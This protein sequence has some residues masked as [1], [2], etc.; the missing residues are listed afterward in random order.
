MRR[1]ASTPAWDAQ[2]RSQSQKAICVPR[3]PVA[4]Q[5]DV[6][7]RRRNRE[8]AGPRRFQVVETGSRPTSDGPHERQGLPA[9]PR[10]DHESGG[11]PAAPLGRH[12]PTKETD[13]CRIGRST[14]RGLA[15]F[16]E[17]PPTLVLGGC[18]RPACTPS[19]GPPRPHRRPRRRLS[20][21]QLRLAASRSMTQ[22]SPTVLQNSPE[23]I[24]PFHRSKS[25]CSLSRAAPTEPSS[26]NAVRITSFAS[27]WS[28]R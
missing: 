2:R 11:E 24:S 21:R 5:R 14:G 3:G 20:V 9:N 7:R 15:R 16:A 27:N 4:N 19:A 26:R 1:E 23:A 22:D 6:L 17:S 13:Y 18:A 10:S 8:S 28:T 12:R 25:G